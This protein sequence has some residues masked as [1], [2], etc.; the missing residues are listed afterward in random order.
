MN[1]PGGNL[2]TLASVALIGGERQD[3][4]PLLR[5]DPAGDLI[6]SL[7]PAEHEAALLSAAAIAG[8]YEAA[9][10]TLSSL[11][12][13]VLRG[14]SPM[15]TRP[16]W[17]S[18]SSAHLQEILF[19]RYRQGVILSQ[20]LR[21]AVAA[22]RVSPPDLLPDLLEAGRKGAEVR[23][24]ISQVIGERGRWLAACNPE[25]SYVS[26]QKPSYEN[27]EQVHTLW[28]TGTRAER[29]ALLTEYRQV[30]RAAARALVEETWATDPPEDR[31]AFIEALRHEAGLDDEPLL[32]R[33]QDDKRKEVR[34]AAVALLSKIPGSKL[35]S[36]MQDRALAAISLKRGLLSPEK[37]ELTLPA[38]C[39]AAMIRDGIEPKSHDAGVGER[40]HWFR[41]T[42]VRTSPSVLCERLGRTRAQLLQMATRSEWKVV[43]VTGLKSAALRFG[44]AELIRELLRICLADAEIM[45]AVGGIRSLNLAA[46]LPR[47]EVE[48]IAIG[49]MKS[50]NSRAA[51]HYAI[52]LIITIVD[53]WSIE[54]TAA[55]AGFVS[56]GMNEC[57]PNSAEAWVYKDILD[58]IS[59]LAPTQIA[60]QVSAVF[61]SKSGGEDWQKYWGKAVVDCLDLLRF[62]R[63]MITAL[64]DSA[65]E[66]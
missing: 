57:A 41:E 38:E 36:R 37:I 31:A 45:R 14:P 64:D 33:A 5:S 18:L 53:G 17:S 55:I 7:D 25:W 61:S 50:P 12:L 56:M 44:D 21:A 34:T 66:N 6:R 46:V 62:R 9:G 63:D 3:L 52:D 30:D 47:E 27:P 29:V 60:E 22:G 49:A 42:L 48:T 2:Q 19:G 23:D 59:W 8:L 11:P 13:T 16:T 43:L 26:A 51:S 10:R 20:W 32:E 35:S 58:R 65:G 28:E 1:R 39:N 54:L 24:L 15:E 40:A 4:A